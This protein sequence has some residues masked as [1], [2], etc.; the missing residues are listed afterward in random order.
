MTLRSPGRQAARPWPA[1]ALAALVLAA[2]SPAGCGGS[3]SSGSRAAPKSAA[4]AVQKPGAYSYATR[5]ADRV[6][7]IVSGHHA[8]PRVTTVTVSRQGCD[9][10]ERWDALPE[11]W[12]ESTSCVVGSRWRLLSLVDYH[13]FFG[14]SLEQ[15]YDCRGRFVPRPSLVRKGFQWT[16]R[17]GSTG[18]TATLQG[19]ALGVKRLKV[20]GKPVQTVLLRLRAQL[21]G[22]IRGTNVIDSWL[23]R[24]TGLLVRRVVRSDTTVDS[25]VGTVTGRERYSLELRSLSP[26]A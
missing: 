1:A 17:C 24:S 12:S 26:E 23:L 25:S 21:R 9:L 2:F 15:R 8:Y 13:E 20:G 11:R 19:T 3:G 14:E 22:R 10:V 18:S 5:G 6:E 7:A 16:D 4:A